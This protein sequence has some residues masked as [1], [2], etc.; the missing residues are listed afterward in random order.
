MRKQV[1]VVLMTAAVFGLTGCQVI[2]DA[3][4]TPEEIVVDY[5]VS[6]SEI[7]NTETDCD[8]LSKALHDYC[9]AREA[10]V[11]QA[12]TDTVKRIERNE[13]TREELEALKNKLEPVSKTNMTSCL[14]SPSVTS[15]KLWCMK[16]ILSALSSI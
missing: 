4:S 13:I 6:V 1:F 7:L 12:V 16:P 14:L 3:I 11:T 5:A 15:E 8:K 2:K 9:S 10:K